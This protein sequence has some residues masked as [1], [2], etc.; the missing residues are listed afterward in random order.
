MRFKAFLLILFF[1][2]TIIGGINAKWRSSGR[3]SGGSR[4]G[5]YGSSHRTSSHQSTNAGS[6]RGSYGSSPSHTSISHVPTSSAGHRPS[7]HET[8]SRPN[9]VSHPIGSSSGPVTPQ[10]SK[11]INT[12]F[13]SA[14]GGGARRPVQT[15]AAG[16]SF[17]TSYPPVSTQN[18]PTAPAIQP[19]APKEQV[20]RPTGTYQNQGSNAPYI[21]GHSTTG[22]TRPPWSNPYGSGSPS[23]VPS[24][25]NYPYNP[26]SPVNPIAPSGYQPP[27]IGFKDHVY[28]QNHPTSMNSPYGQP[29]MGGH[30]PHS[31]PPPSGPWP[32]HSY[33]PPNY[34]PSAMPMGNPYS[35]H[36]SGGAYHA[37]G[38]ANYP[39]QPQV[40]AQPASQPFI[41]GQTVI[42]VPGQQ[43]SGRGFGQLVKEA[44]V[45]STINAGVNRLINPHTHYTPSTSDSSSS[46]QPAATTHVTYNNQYFNTPPATNGAPNPTPNAGAGNMPSS[47]LEYG[48]TYPTSSPN[49]GVSS[50]VTGTGNGGGGNIGTVNGGGG[51]IGTGQTGNIGIGQTGNVA[52]PS[53]AQTNAASNQGNLSNNSNTVANIP[54]YKISDNDLFT[55]SEDLFSKSLDVSKYIK[56]NLQKRSTSSNITDEAK[57]PL[58]AVEPELMH[59]PSIYVT[60]ALYD[61][62]GHDFRKKVNRTL[63][64]REDENLLIDTFLNTNVMGRAMQWLADRG[65]IDPDDFERK[66]VFRR[67]WF[68][69]FSGSTCGFER[70]FASENYDVDIVGV[71]DWIYFETE[72]SKK[73]INY[74]SYVDELKFGNKASLLKLNFDMDGVVRPNATIFVGTM[75]ELEMSLYTICFF[76]RQN[77]L[78]PVSFGGTKFNIYT[79][80][81]TYF[82]NEIIDLAFPTF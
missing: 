80:S 44:L 2:F 33:P 1:V 6:S 72:E 43:D 54:F 61:M 76:A 50:P 34:H 8:Q 62:Y 51:N 81:F 4:S 60:R 45:F 41:P 18:K 58:L 11:D 3:S 48:N 25:T 57:E 82:G 7:G 23:S 64:I 24:P 27:P 53:T 59:Y 5:S 13:L 37:P 28:P 40:L 15:N 39:Q 77:N 10:H 56:L 79:H 29:Q 63:Q 36:P 46:S 66:D 65:F 49:G 16:T 73:H 38:Q 68:T 78:C 17:G 67:I 20:I 14:E 22:Q 75:P 71:Q 30:Y 19:T 12:H 52:P 42:M 55:I 32:T 9:P 35:L 47:P 26:S 70:V 21:P 69:M 31:A 74:M